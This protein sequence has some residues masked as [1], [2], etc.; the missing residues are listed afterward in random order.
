[1]LMSCRYNNLSGFIITFDE[2]IMSSPDKSINILYKMIYFEIMK[3]AQ[4]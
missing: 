1:M 4:V 3:L 2:Y